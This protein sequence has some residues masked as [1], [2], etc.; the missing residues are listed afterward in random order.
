MKPIMRRA[1]TLVLLAILP[2]APA[3]ANVVTDWS[4]HTGNVLLAATL[5]APTAYR[6]V[7]VTQTAVYYAVNA[8]EDAYPGATPL[9]AVT[10]PASI[11]AAVA[12]ATRATLRIL[13]PAQAEA[14]DKL[15]AAALASVPAGPARDAGIALGERAG[16]LALEHAAGDGA[17]SQEAYRPA[18]SPGV[19]VPTTVPVA[20]TWPG[21]SPWLM[22][23]A[24]AFRPDPPPALGSETWARD[25][26]EIRALGARNSTTRTAEQT[27]V[28]RFWETTSPA[29]YLRVATSLIE[30]REWSPARSARLL[31]ALSQSMD[32]ALVAVFDAKYHYGF[33]RPITAIRNGD[34]DGNRATEGE[35]GWRPLVETPMHPEYPCAH[36][37]VAGAV[38]AV[39]GAANGDAPAPV[40]RSSSPTAQGATRDWHS[41]DDFV[42]EVASARIYAGVHYRNST[43][44]GAAMG[45]RIGALAV[46]R[47]GLAAGP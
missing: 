22:D 28:A 24:S 15:Y 12:A 11:E 13:M 46:A 9:P 38:S 1:A 41:L 43:E 27:Q 30:S 19:Y 44:V 10:G 35:P 40:L 2:A 23:R 14:V 36:C 25:Y 34:L 21:R 4:A 18:T 8:V 37:I 3:P 45:R 47:F 16:A 39:L 7:A 42:R 5:P 31:A 6:A 33:W 32:D 26:A 17:D 29:I 20:T